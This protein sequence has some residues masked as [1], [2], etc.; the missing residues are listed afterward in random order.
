MRACVCSPHAAMITSESCSHASITLQTDVIYRPHLACKSIVLKRSK[1]H[2]KSTH[3]SRKE[4]YAKSKP[5]QTAFIWLPQKCA[6]YCSTR[7]AQMA[8]PTVDNS[9]QQ[10]ATFLTTIH[11]RM[12]MFPHE[13][14]KEEMHCCY[15]CVPSRKLRGKQGR[16]DLGIPVS[17]QDDHT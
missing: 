1:P 15:P 14:L 17:C 5:V 16:A 4:K 6:V 9:R 10:L 2:L 13:H 12:G 7:P 3:T 11:H 8:S